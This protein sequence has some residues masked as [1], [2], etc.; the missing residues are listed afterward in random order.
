MNGLRT[1]ERDPSIPVRAGDADLCPPAPE[2]LTALVDSA[3]RRDESLQAT[4]ARLCHVRWK[5]HVALAAL[6]AVRFDDGA[7][8]LVT[9]KRYATD[10]AERAARGTWR[11]RTELE[12]HLLPGAAWPGERVVV[13]VFPWDRALPGLARAFDVKRTCRRLAETPRFEGLDLR[14]RRSSALLL[15]YKPERRAVVRFDAVLRAEDRRRST[16]PVGVRILPR[17]DAAR[18]A[19]ARRDARLDGLGLAPAWIGAEAR[20]GLVFEEWLDVRP[21]AHDDFSP[22][23]EA[24]LALAGLHALPCADEQVEIG[25]AALADALPL[26]EVD[27][28]LWTAA[29]ALVSSAWCG[30]TRATWVH[31]DFHPDQTARETTAGRLRV[32]DWDALRIGNPL[33]DLASWIADAV[34]VEDP[35]APEALLA[36]YLEGGGIEPDP[37]ELDAAVARGLFLRA[38][39]ALRR[40]ESDAPRK[41]EILLARAKA[42]RLAHGGAR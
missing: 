23:R 15:R 4:S 38:A 5:P 7:E 12:P 22:S 9:W 1:Y 37:A 14:H 21:C 3:L 10:K 33:E 25:A 6:Y 20:S 34:A 39:A 8:R 30:S 35:D 41:A 26:F 27:R 11:S 31:G 32:L 13:S 18:V 2:R 17:S 42:H 28:K 36:G 24:G 19:R 29:H 40:I 16:L